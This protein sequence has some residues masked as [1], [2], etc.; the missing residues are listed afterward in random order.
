MKD[1]MEKDKKRGIRNLHR[2][3]QIYESHQSTKVILS[4]KGHL[5]SSSHAAIFTQPVLTPIHLTCFSKSYRFRDEPNLTL[6]TT[7]PNPTQPVLTVWTYYT[8]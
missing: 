4:K 8:T 7:E 5:H 6:Y 3:K 2:K 1:G